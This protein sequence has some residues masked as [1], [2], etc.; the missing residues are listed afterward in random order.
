VNAARI[1][2][3]VILGSALAMAGLLGAPAGLV[4]LIGAAIGATA[5]LPGGCGAAAFSNLAQKLYDR[6]AWQAHWSENY[7]QEGRDGLL[8]GL[9]SRR[10]SGVDV[11]PDLFPD[12]L[13]ESKAWL[14]TLTSIRRLPERRPQ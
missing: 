4:I 13:Q 9:R 2:G 14:R 1:A 7:L 5:F 11:P 8:A 6:D 3:F 12:D 10:R